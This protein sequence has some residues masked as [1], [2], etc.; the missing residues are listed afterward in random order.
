[1][2]GTL[3]AIWVKRARRGR[4]D[5]V[6]EVELDPS[7][8]IA[9]NADRGRR[10]VTILDG[11]EWERR[12]AA[13]GARLDPVARRA[14]LLVRGIDLAES[15]GRVLLVGACRIRIDGETKPCRQMDEALPGLRE[16]LYARW[17]GGAW[18]AVVVGGV[19]ALGDRV[20]WADEAA[21]S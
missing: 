20:A 18:G 7:R 12:L 4:M 11:E 19:I 6:C 17:G 14:N 2:R 3:E 1:M 15:R 13:L 5:A 10:Q 21:G 16:A 8:G 9:G